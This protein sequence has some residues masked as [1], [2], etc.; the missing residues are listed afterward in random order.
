MARLM[1]MFTHPRSPLIDVAITLARRW[2]QGHIVDGAPALRHAFKVARKIEEHVSDVSPDLI[3]AAILHDA[4]F[5]APATVNLDAILT[6]QLSPD[7]LRI[8][9]GLER[10]HT[11]LDSDVLPVLPTDEPDV[12]IASA[13]DKVIS[14]GAI[15]WRAHRAADMK[16]YWGKRRPFIKR[17]PYFI[18]FAELAG[19]H[20]P[21]DLARELE[22]VVGQAEDSTT[23]YRWPREVPSR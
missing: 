18:A 6:E 17:V 11:A 14:I 1:G 9:R 20:L 10:E 3:A 5:F 23:P 16:V 15:T 7:V 22:L 19:P 21:V 2:C 4:P 8:V 12:L 13:V